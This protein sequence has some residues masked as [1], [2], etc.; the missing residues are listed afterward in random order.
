MNTFSQLFEPRSIAVVGVSDD[1]ARPGSQAVRALLANGF[2]GKLYPVNPKYPAFEGLPCFPSVAAIPESIDVVVIGVPAKGVLAVLEDCAAKKVPFA[3]I[4]SGGF[5][6]SGPEGIERERRMLEIAREGNIRLIGPNC[7]GFVNVHA[8]VYAAFGSMTREPKLQRGSV[9]LV[10]QSGGFGYSIALAC[11]E[12]GIGFRHVVATGNESDID[13]IQLIDALLDDDKTQCIVAYIEGTSDGRALLDV[14][15]RALAAGKP[16]LLWKGGVTEQGARAAASHTASMTGSYD[17]YRAMFKQTGIVEIA[18][19][20]EAVD[21]LRAFAPAKYPA[22]RGVVVMGVSGGSAIVFA[23]A[24]ERVGMDMIELSPETQARLAEVVPNIGAVHNPIDLTAGY[25]SKANQDKLELALRAALDDPKAASIC[26]NLAT[27]G[28]SGCLAAAEVFRKVARDT[29]KPIVVFSSAP[30]SEVGDAL[31]ILDEARI[32]VFASPSRA[33][34]ALAVLAT[35]RERQLSIAADTGARLDDAAVVIDPSLAAILGAG[36]ALSEAQSKALLE[37]AGVPVTKDI[38]VQDARAAELDSA[39]FPVVVKIVSQDI[40]HK[41]EVGGVKVGIADRAALTAAI[42]E[43]LG[44]ARQHVPD[45]RIDGVLVAP[46]IRGGFELI[47]GVVND[48]VFG[49]VVVVGAGGIYAEL[50]KDTSCRLAPFGIDT[51]RQMLDELQC[52]PILNGARGK[53]PLDVDAAARVL[54]SL[55]QF[56]WA[57]RDDVMEVDINPL[58][59]LEHGVMAAD[60]LVVPFGAQLAH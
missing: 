46:M 59:V 43:V 53:P 6:E 55:S 45:A 3:V 21:Y 49:P 30:A 47:A 40:P 8:S 22:G 17:F 52:R 48:E 38:I 32:P 54:A 16:V 25:F 10:T 57:T 4:L 28:K 44:N 34:R 9:S 7:L 1:A 27:T 2:S 31:R 33:A 58:F 39:S 24:G 23:D 42:D 13:T 14:G 35:Y 5:R 19:L 41:T 12:A 56:A 60:A 15:R 50:L 36:G 11:A 20:H 29:D 51:A 26:V 37:A 18:E